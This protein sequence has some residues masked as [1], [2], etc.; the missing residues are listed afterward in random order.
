MATTATTPDSTSSSSRNGA[1]ISSTGLLAADR[2]RHCKPLQFLPL[3]DASL[4]PPPPI[5]QPRKQRISRVPSRSSL[6]A[7]VAS[8]PNNTKE[9]VAAEPPTPLLEVN[10]AKESLIMKLP[11]PCRNVMSI[12]SIVNADN[13][14]AQRALAVPPLVTAAPTPRGSP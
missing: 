4:Y 14:N 9:K 8:S 12:S 11:T 13:T 1:P 6:A 3:L 5:A 10:I 7:K 2:Y